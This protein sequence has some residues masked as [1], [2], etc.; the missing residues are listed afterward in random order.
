MELQHEDFKKIRFE[1]ENPDETLDESALESLFED[2]SLFTAS[3]LDKYNIPE[4]RV[5]LVIGRSAI[6][7]IFNL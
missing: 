4:E 5:K 3:L 1:I 7:K 6:E 2:F